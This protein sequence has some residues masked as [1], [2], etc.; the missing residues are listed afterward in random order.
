MNGFLRWRLV[1][2]HVL[3]AVALIVAALPP[4]AGA[5]PAT[6]SPSPSGG[7]ADGMTY[8]TVSDQVLSWSNPW[9][10]DESR[11]ERAEAHDMVFLGSGAAMLVIATG[12]WTMPDARAAAFSTLAV[13]PVAVTTLD[14]GETYW[15]HFVPVN[16]VPS[17]VFGLATSAPDGV[18]TVVTMI[19]APVPEFASGL[20]SA[21]AGIT[22]DGAPP[23]KGVD[24]AA[25]QAQLETQVPEVPVAEATL[26]PFE[27]VDSWT[28]E[29]FGYT[30][31]WADGWSSLGMR[32]NNTFML[33]PDDKAVSVNMTAIPRQGST[34][35]D[36]A[37][38]LG[39][40]LQ[41]IEADVE[42]LDPVVGANNTIVVGLFKDMAIVEE[43]LFLDDG[44]TV[45]VVT[46]G[47]GDPEDVVPVAESYR[48]SVRIDGRA[49]LEGWDGIVAQL[50]EP[51][52]ASAPVPTAASTAVEEVE[53]ADAG[54]VSE[55]SYVSPQFGTSVQWSEEW[56]LSPGS[57]VETDPE[58]R[59]DILRIKWTGSR[60][61]L[62]LVFSIPSYGATI[63]QFVAYASSE[64]RIAA[65]FPMKATVVLADA[66]STRGGLL[67][68]VPEMANTYIYEE[69]RLSDDGSTITIV[70]LAGILGPAG[71][72]ERDLTPTLTAAQEGVTVNAEPVL[73]YFTVDT[74]VQ[75]FS[76]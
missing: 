9:V 32:N 35:Q 36:W 23:L 17:G 18:S 25:L 40:R 60:Q 21:Q 50:P 57:P 11:S 55:T 69:F 49:P 61:N 51:A 27:P 39:P 54:M 6:G 31:E 74:V 43:V 65:D 59:T 64:E 19:V 15:F 73:T 48:T 16:G 42:V 22:L 66:T 4:A 33:G 41:G 45:V 7:L 56:A 62:L 70:R 38:E 34:P 68:H 2:L 10:F 26:P 72:V 30:V 58:N 46:L 53:Y 52:A 29:A 71:N 47:I 67:I 44:Q 3:A 76:Q 1:L 5:Q 63:D 14:E 12:D 13:D 37:N 28:D 75:A 24:G 8:Q 20:G